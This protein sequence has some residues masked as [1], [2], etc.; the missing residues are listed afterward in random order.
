MSVRRE[1]G[2]SVRGGGRGECEREGECER[3]RERG[4]SVRRRGR[5]RGGRK[6]DE[7]E[8]GRVSVRGEGER[9]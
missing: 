9:G 8:R 3:G 5:V 4:V 6:E 7:C 2:V 1:G